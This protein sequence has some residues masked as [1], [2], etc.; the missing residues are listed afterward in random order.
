M[1][2]AS[3]GNPREATGSLVRTQIFSELVPFWQSD[4]RYEPL[5]ERTL[6]FG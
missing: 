4:A 2:R 3:G 5:R 1:E 6:M